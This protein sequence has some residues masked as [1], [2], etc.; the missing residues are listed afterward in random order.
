MKRSILIISLLFFSFSSFAQSNV[1]FGFTTSPGVSWY[2]ADNLD[3]DS[4]GARF[5][6]N[7][8]A[9]VDFVIDN[10]QRYTITSG[11]T[12]DMTGGKLAG[13]S[14]DSLN[15]GSSS[16]TTKVQY[17]EIPL[18][19]KLRSNETSNNLT[20]YGTLGFVNSFRIRSRGTYDYSGNEG[21]FSGNNVR[22]TNLS[23]H[24][25]DIQKISPYHFALHFEGGVEFRVSDN[26][27]IVGGIYFRNGFT[28]VIDDNDKER[29]VARGIGL[30]VAVMF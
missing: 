7:Y 27:A 1:R 9:I 3:L 20:F 15:S 30:R 17:I 24:P 19:L 11:V 4:K 12:I 2:S 8:G 18:G 16:L 28:N 10:N 6:F 5:S 26:T 23:F 13:F 14:N 25:Y 29:V 21:N 22:I